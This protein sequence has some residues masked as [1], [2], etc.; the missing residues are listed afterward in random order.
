MTAAMSCIDFAVAQLSLS[1]SPHA[2]SAIVAASRH[3]SA[4]SVGVLLDD[5]AAWMAR[6]HAAARVAISCVENVRVVGCDTTFDF[7]GWTAVDVGARVLC[8]DDV[9][10]VDDGQPVAFEDESIECR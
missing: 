1:P 8:A 10:R 3:L 6:P 5:R 4:A 9:E 2:V 7:C